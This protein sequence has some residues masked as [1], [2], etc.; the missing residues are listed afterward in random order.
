MTM[1]WYCYR[2][3]NEQGMRMLNI[4]PPEICID[5]AKYCEIEDCGKL[6]PKPDGMTIANYKHAH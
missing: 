1:H 5:T 4:T 6:I 3:G 2:T